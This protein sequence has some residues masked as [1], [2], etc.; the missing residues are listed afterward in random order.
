MVMVFVDGFRRRPV[1]RAVEGA[2]GVSAVAAISRAGGSAV[3]CTAQR[4]FG[5]NCLPSARGRDRRLRR[6]MGASIT[7]PCLQSRLP[8]RLP[9][10]GPPGQRA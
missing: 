10:H 2:L 3:L 6:M 9:R 8:R 4:F 5:T 7:R 1:R